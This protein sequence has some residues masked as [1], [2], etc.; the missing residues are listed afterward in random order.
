MTRLTPRVGA[1]SRCH[2]GENTRNPV[3]AQPSHGLENCDPPAVDA[4]RADMD[5]AHPPQGRGAT[6]ADA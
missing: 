1:W 6:S 4:L 2:Y 5:T 3:A